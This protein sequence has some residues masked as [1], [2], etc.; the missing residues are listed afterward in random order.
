MNGY[1]NDVDNAKEFLEKEKKRQEQRF[2]AFAT[3]L[4][5][6]SL[7]QLDSIPNKQWYD[8][9][10]TR[11]CLLLMYKE[12]ESSLTQ[13]SVFGKS[14]TDPK[15]M[16]RRD[17]TQLSPLKVNMYRQLNKERVVSSKENVEKRCST[18]YE[19][20]KLKQALSFIKTKAL[21]KH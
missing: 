16:I 9:K 13:K 20:D 4:D 21:K 7:C 12:H 8:N 5:K 10:F 1:L 2:I 18:E 19:N 14:Y 17:N 3:F 15:S 11:T 6:P